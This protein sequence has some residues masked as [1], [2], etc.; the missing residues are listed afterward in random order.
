MFDDGSE[1]G[2]WDFYHGDCAPGD[3]TEAPV[4]GAGLAN[5][6]SVFCIE[7][8]GALDLRTDEDGGQVGVCVFDDGSECEEWAYF[9][10]ECTPGG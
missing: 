9:R 8:G 6:A 10:G 1:C 3:S 4:P 5:P 2:E 7:Q